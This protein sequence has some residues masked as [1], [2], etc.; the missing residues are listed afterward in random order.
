MGSPELHRPRLATWPLQPDSNENGDHGGMWSR[1]D[2]SLV[3]KL[4]PWL[5][6][7]D[8]ILPSSRHSMSPTS[9]SRTAR[10]ARSRFFSDP[11]DTHN[12]QAR[13]IESEL[14]AAEEG[15]EMDLSGE[16]P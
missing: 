16:P 13:L 15:V 6:A 11:T 12:Y 9:T 3:L 2:F 14:H 10:S 1:V 4:P 5:S 7:L 8:Y